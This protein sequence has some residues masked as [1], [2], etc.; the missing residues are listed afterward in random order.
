MLAAGWPAELA[1]YAEHDPDASRVMAA[2]HDVVNLGD[3]TTVDWRAA[4]PVDVLAAGYPCQSFSHAGK[5]KG[6]QDER[7]VWPHV[8][9][10]V[11]HL[12]PRLV[13][14]E[15]VAGHLARGFG[16][17]L[18]DLAEI[19]YDARWLCLRASDVGAPHRRDRVFVAA[20]PVD[21]DGE[22]V[23]LEPVPVGARV[24]APVVADDRPADGLMPTPTARDG[25]GGP[26]HQG[27]DGGLNLRTFV[28]LLPTPAARDSGR[29]GGWGDQPGRPLSETVH[30]LL[31]TPRASDS[32]KSGPNQRGSSGDLALAAVVARLPTPTATDARGGRNATPGRKD[33]SQHH[34]G[35]TLCDVAY[36]SRWDQ[37]AAAVE[38]WERI[39]GRDAPDPTTPPTRRGSKPQLSARFVEWLMGLDDGYVTAH[40]PRNAALRILGNGLVPA[41]GAAA[42]S[43]LIGA[44]HV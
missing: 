9:D 10:A 39:A 20:T 43:S 32:D 27:R 21:A 6:F 18:G 17:V 41:Q 23:R 40:V 13:L 3:I 8:A 16:R 33:G 44:C 22:P 1:W 25:M 2:H 42:Y 31:P 28:S 37:Y 19:G 26:G 12:R 11:R 36:A 4:E 38:R 29:G 34:G 15:N 5:R 14:L 35:W 30:R 24:A 7:A